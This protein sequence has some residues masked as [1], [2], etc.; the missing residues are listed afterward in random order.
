M[1]TRKKKKKKKIK[2]K[3]AH[4]CG[5]IDIPTPCIAVLTTSDKNPSVAWWAFRGQIRYHQRHQTHH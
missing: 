3:S 4:V 2:K 5:R 1:L